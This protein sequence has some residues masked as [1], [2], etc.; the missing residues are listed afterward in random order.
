MRVALL[1]PPCGDMPGAF[2]AMWE[3]VSPVLG[4]ADTVALW[5]PGSGQEVRVELSA[6]PEAVSHVVYGKAQGCVL[7]EQAIRWTEGLY[8]RFRPDLLLCYGSIAGQELAVRLSARLGCPCLTQIF[9]LEKGG[10]ALLAKKKVC[11]SYL[12][13]ESAS[14]TFPAVIALQKRRV[15]PVGDAVLCVPKHSIKSEEIPWPT[16]RPDYLLGRESLESTEQNPLET[17]QLLLVGGKGL[18]NKVACDKLRLLAQRWGA[19]LAWSRQ[20]AINGFGPLDAVVGQSGVIA[21]PKRC[22]TF[23]VSGAAAFLAGVEAAERLYAV[24]TDLDAP[25]FRC[26]DAGIVADAEAV[27]DL[28]LQKEKV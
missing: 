23:G 5:L 18:G 20:A 4:D 16:E 14:S 2:A 21:A 3:T 15:M 28:L 11:S 10:E 17:A 25:I 8:S 27:I 22:I 1:L 13:W 6:L 19:A 26:C 7:P 9:T 12:T 24:N